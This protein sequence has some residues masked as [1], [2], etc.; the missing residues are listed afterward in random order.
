MLNG[1]TE[2]CPVPLITKSGIQIPVETRVSHGYWNDN[3]VIFGVTKDISKI[4]F[5][6]EKFSKVFY[7]NPSA[8]GLS[9]SVTHKYIEVNEAFYTL[10]GFD[11]SEVIGKTAMELGILSIEK[12]NEIAILINSGVNLGNEN[13]YNLE[14]DLKT[15]NGDTKHVLMS[16]ENINVQ[17][18]IYRY[19]VVHDITERKQAEIA[20][21]ES[22]KRSKK[23]RE[24]VVSLSIEE[25]IISGNVPIALQKLTKVLSDTVSVDRASVWSLS[26]DG[27]KMIC[28]CLYEASNNEYSQGTVLNVTDFPNYFKTIFTDSIISADDAQSDPRTNEFTDVYLKPLGITSM[29]DAGIWIEGKPIGVVCFEHVGEKRSWHA[30]EEAFANTAATIIMQIYSNADRKLAAEN[31]KTK[32]EQLEKANAEK[33][34]LFSII[35]H[36]LRSPF[37]AFLGYTEIMVEDAHKM[38]S[39][40]LQKIA[41]SIHNSANN[42]FRLL[43][44]LLEWSMVQRGL[45]VFKP[46][47]IILSKLISHTLEVFYEIAK[48]KEIEII[49]EIPENISVIADVSMFET[50]IRNLI[51]NALK[52]TMRGGSVFIS[53]KEKKGIVEVSVKDSGIGMSKKMVDNLFKINNQMSR[54]GTEK[55]LSSGLGLLLCKEFVEKQNGK[56][57]VESEE[58]KGS[59]F[60]FS[61]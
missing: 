37:T 22:E 8:C 3:P 38:T 61:I 26:D 30:E 56:I 17:D 39:D 60:Y 55:E 28:L 18:K 2:F 48:K 14:V 1:I 58:G 40:N 15:K 20:L 10:F 25:S 57:W 4:Q 29:L 12:F 27:M 54:P 5:S 47:T 43:T 6:E 46:E 32:N 31:L 41:V 19:T 21:Q 33:D 45:I 34:K 44:N 49:T 24:S 53:A 11:K 50:I 59:T 16:A 13:V 51:S 52:F 23:Q 36:D 42:L 7:L 9:D 35:A